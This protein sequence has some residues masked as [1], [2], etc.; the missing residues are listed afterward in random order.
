MSI[1][2]EEPIDMICGSVNQYHSYIPDHNYII[3]VD[4]Q[5]EGSHYNAVVVFDLEDRVI[6][7]E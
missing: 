7:A 1:K 4:C 5:E 2:T 3:S 6:A